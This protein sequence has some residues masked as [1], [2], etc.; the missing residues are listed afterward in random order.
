MKK[1]KEYSEIISKLRI[2]NF[3]ALLK[4]DF[5]EQL[6]KIKYK[7]KDNNH[8]KALLNSYVLDC[9][10]KLKSISNKNPNYTNWDSFIKSFNSW[11]T[12]ET[13]LFFKNNVTNEKSKV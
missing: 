13:Y 4:E 9:T 8:L 3:V 7:A 5:L 10:Q 1:A 11:A 12:N 6:P 2:N